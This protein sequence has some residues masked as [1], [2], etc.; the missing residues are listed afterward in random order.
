M[1][2]GD[3]FAFFGAAAA[4]SPLAGI[5]QQQRMP[6]IGV[7]VV[8]S[9][10]SE[11]FWRLFQEDLRQLG[12]IEEKNIRFEFRSDEGQASRLPALASE[13]VWLKVDLIVAWFTPA[14]IA[15]RQATSKI[16]IVMALV[17]NP[18]ETG[19]VESLASPGGNVTGM[20]AVG[21]ELAGKCVQ[22]VRELLPLANRIA[23]LVNAPDPFAEPFLRQIRLNGAAS[24]TAI[25]PIMIHSAAELDAAFSEMEEK[26]PDAVIVQPS[27][28]IKRV[29][30]LAVRHRIPAVSFIRDFADEGGLMSYGSEEADAYRRAAVFVD[31]ILK[32]AKPGDLPIE[33]PTHFEL[34]VN[35]KTAKALNL[36]IP[37][38]ILARADEVIE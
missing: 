8:Q 33:Q 10:G 38:L 16:P 25:D 1:R 13:L 28:P 9:P 37:P 24:A 35:M 22:L 31:K 17:G 12:Y 2:R 4:L 23:A 21:A 3:L 29:A 14:A 19:L 36:T 7:L 34:V 20:A 5:A 6:T 15:A 26:R 32:G 18:V 11:R 27:L 30:A